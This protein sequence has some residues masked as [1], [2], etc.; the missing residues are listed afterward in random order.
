MNREEFVESELRKRGYG[1]DNEEQETKIVND[2]A[3]L[4]QIPDHLRVKDS[5]FTQDVSEEMK[6]KEANTRAPKTGESLTI[7]DERSTVLSGGILEVP[8]SIELRL[9]NIEETERAKERMKNQEQIASQY[10]G[11]NYN[12]NYNMHHR[13]YLQEQMQSMENLKEQLE[14]K[15]ADE[16]TDDDYDEKDREDE[17]NFERQT[18]FSQL[19]RPSETASDEALL[20]RFKK[21]FKH[22]H[23]R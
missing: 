22:N 1:K 13:R 9:K 4:F 12:M 8:I 17:E 14:R 2:E 7:E 15:E 10:G 18:Q 6:H 21:R 11:Q 19:K 16:L 5:L 20:E 3:E 23:N